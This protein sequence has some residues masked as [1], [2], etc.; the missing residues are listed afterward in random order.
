VPNYFGYTNA[1]LSKT[2]LTNWATRPS[3]KELALNCPK[4]LD[5]ITFAGRE[6]AMAD[7]W[8][9]S[10]QQKRRSARPGGTWPYDVADS[11]SGSVAIG[12]RAKVPT[13]PYHGTVRSF[14]ALTED[15]E[16]SAR[17]KTGLTNAIFFD[18]PCRERSELEGVR[19]PL[20][21]HQQR[22]ALRLIS[23]SPG[24]GWP[25]GRES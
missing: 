25:I 10:I 17:W 13:Y 14:N 23:Q 12:G 1:P 20:P 9:C 3:K 11:N 16:T 22:Q 8:F 2:T 6:W 5:S 18:G 4:K 15:A 24:L 7:L 19:K 21:G